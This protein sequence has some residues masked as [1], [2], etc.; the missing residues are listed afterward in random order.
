MGAGVISRVLLLAL[1]LTA[2]APVQQGSERHEGTFSSAQDLRGFIRD[3]QPSSLSV[4]IRALAV[5]DAVPGAAVPEAA[6][7]EYSETNTQVPGID[8]A[9]ILKTDGAYIYTVTDN[10]LFIIS[11]GKDAG[12]ESTIVLKNNPRGLFLDGDTLFVF[13]NFYDVTYFKEHGIRP[14]QMTFV[15]VYDVTDRTNPKK[16]RSFLFEGSYFQGRMKEGWVYLVVRSRPVIRPLPMPLILEDGI[17]SHVPLDRITAYPADDAS[18]FVTVHAIN[19]ETLLT[20]SRTVL[21]SNVQTLYMSQKN[22]YLASTEYVNEWRMRQ[23]V[24]MELLMDGLAEEDAG[25]IRKIRQTDSQVLSPE[26]KRS[27]IYSVYA[28]Y[29]P[30]DDADFER[31]VEDELEKR[32]KQYEAR[33]STVLHVLR[34]QDGEVTPGPSATIPGMVKDQFSMDEY[35]GVLRVATTLNSLGGVGVR[36]APVARRDR[37]IVPGTENRIYTLDENLGVLDVLQGIA[38]GERIFSTRFFKD[39]LYMVTFRQTDPFFVFDLSDPNGIRELGR[40][41]IPGFSRY[42]HPYD[43][44]HIIGFGRD[45]TE[46]GGQLGLKISLF[47]VGDVSTPREVARWAAKE[48]YSQSAA[49]W[50]HKA[51]LFD[52]ERQLLVIPAYAGSGRQTYNGA[53]VFRISDSSIELRGIIDH[54]TGGRYWRPQVERSLYVGTV[55]YTKSP[56]LLRG[57]DL[58]DLSPVVTVRLETGSA[59]PYPVY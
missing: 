25:L 12:I 30:Y 32:L 15:D 48:R 11:T 51:F 53:L 58:A 13:G 1:L 14:E 42:L 20:R 33:E 37:E 28:R 54:G 10:T 22:L 7:R 23:D 26:E 34:V 55:L 24:Q 21:V 8:E 18:D 40:L 38:P 29:L 17:V 9:D 49:E 52:K 43:E 45:A 27:K 5:A 44:T 46:R 50:E 4:G 36:E 3:H 31:R 2:C 19:T 35:R 6:V 39:R 59:G 41:K 57:N 56:H 16:E 47:D